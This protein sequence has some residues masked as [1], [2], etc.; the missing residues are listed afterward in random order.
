[1]TATL[2]KNL[3]GFDTIDLL[4]S[5]HKNNKTNRWRMLGHALG[6]HVEYAL[7]WI[8]Y[9]SSIKIKTFYIGVFNKFRVI[10]LSNINKKLAS[11]I[12]C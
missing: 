12:V 6:V 1:M 3:V 7:L 5:K 10:I 2:S 8:L 9:Q 11:F 4:L